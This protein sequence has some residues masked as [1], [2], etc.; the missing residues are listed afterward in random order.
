MMKVLRK[1]RKGGFTLIELIVVIAILGILAAIAVPRFMNVSADAQTKADQATARTIA[2]AVT[3]AS[4]QQN[5]AQPTA[6]QI[7]TFLN[8]ITV[9]TTG[10][11]GW[12]VNFVGTSTSFT[13][14]KGATVVY[15]TTP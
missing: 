1:R 7:N 8:D 9:A 3:M 11:T 14:S 5:G 15:P 6:T 13:V 2:S 10:T 4:A 12:V